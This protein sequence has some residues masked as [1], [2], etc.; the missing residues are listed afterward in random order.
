MFFENIEAIATKK[1]SPFTALHLFKLS[2]KL[3]LAASP[4]PP[5]HG[6]LRSAFSATPLL[7]PA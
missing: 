4:A 5:R 3:T 7:R 6:Y 1:C 2:L